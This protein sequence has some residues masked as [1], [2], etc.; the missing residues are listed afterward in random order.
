M[1][2]KC[3]KWVVIEG[4]KDMEIKVYSISWSL[5][6]I[7]MTDIS[8]L[9]YFRSR[10]SSG[11]SPFDW[12]FIDWSRNCAKVEACCYMSSRFDYQWGTG[13][14]YG[15]RCVQSPDTAIL[16]KGYVFCS[17]ICVMPVSEIT[18]LIMYSIWS[19]VHLQF[20]IR[21]V[22]LVVHTLFDPLMSFPVEG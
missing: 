9:I 16:G 13:H 11:V 7:L 2:H 17:A 4:I 19:V 10:R 1:C 20:P 14:L 3:H 12:N 8:L 6:L 15:G 5:C 22:V 18:N 21:K